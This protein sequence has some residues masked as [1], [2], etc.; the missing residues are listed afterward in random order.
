M[1]KGTDYWHFILVFDKD[2]ITLTTGT[3]ATAD[4]D[5]DADANADAADVATIVFPYL[6][7]LYT[8]FNTSTEGEPRQRWRINISY[9]ITSPGCTRGVISTYYQLGALA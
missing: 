6:S 7:Y 9:R 1:L 4:A 2:I 3:D 8:S 5:A